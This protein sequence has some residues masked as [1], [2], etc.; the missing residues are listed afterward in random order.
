MR[1]STILAVLIVVLANLIMRS[2]A[3]GRLLVPPARS[4][5]W[6]E[7]PARF[8]TYFDDAQMFCGGFQTQWGVNGMSLNLKK[9]RLPEDPVFSTSYYI[10]VFFYYLF[11]W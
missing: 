1:A 7:D 4:S 6:R 8:P 10:C 5:A 3:H 11:A 2:E 9:K